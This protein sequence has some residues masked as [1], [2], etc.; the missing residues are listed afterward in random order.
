LGEEKNLEKVKKSGDK[1][2][3]EERAQ[4]PGGVRETT[5]DDQLVDLGI[6]DPTQKGKNTNLANPRP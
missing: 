1:P 3:K 2:H 5:T 6:D 4:D